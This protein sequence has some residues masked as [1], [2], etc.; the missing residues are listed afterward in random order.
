[1]KAKIVFIIDR[2]GSMGGLESDVIGGFNSFIE[3]QK[4][5]KG[6]ADVSLV[7]FDHEY[8]KPFTN[9]DIQHTKLLNEDTYIPRGTTALLDAVGR[10]ITDVG[11][12]LREMRE[13]DRPEK[14]IVCIITDGHENSSSDYSRSQ[15]KE[16][17]EH[18]QNKYSWE[19]IFFGA[20]MDAFAEG[21]SL[22]FKFDN[23]SNYENT[24]VGNRNAYASM[25]C[26]VANYRTD[27]DDN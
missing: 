25:S 7:L 2:S 1:M 14:V 22:G 27:A 15:I 3:E 21:G 11:K 26:M 10:T 8:T 17:V 13:L 6:E 9:V 24:G 12:E 16:M 23:I 4:K 19:F 5:I 18:Q 20:N